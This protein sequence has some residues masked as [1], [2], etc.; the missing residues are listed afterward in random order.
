VRINLDLDTPWRSG[1]ID[2]PLEHVELPIT[3]NLYPPSSWRQIPQAEHISVP[4]RSRHQ[5]P[6]QPGAGLSGP[7][8]RFT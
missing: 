7:V 3:E 1:A 6:S 2:V 5:L 8:R 4:V